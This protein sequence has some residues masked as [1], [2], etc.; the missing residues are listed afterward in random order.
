MHRRACGSTWLLWGAIVLIS[1]GCTSKE[2]RLRQQRQAVES[3]RASAQLTGRAWVS[4]DVPT[5]FTGDA[6]TQLLQLLDS[7]RSSLESAPASLADSDTAALSQDCERL[8][9]QV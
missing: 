2:D 1:G 6:F 4:A 8:S 3:I 5:P 7:E 9:R